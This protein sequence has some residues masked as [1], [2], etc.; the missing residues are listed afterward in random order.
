MR[1]GRRRGDP[2]FLC[3]GKFDQEPVVAS[4][5]DLEFDPC[6]LVKAG[7]DS[8]GRH[9]IHCDG[10]GGVLAFVPF[11]SLPSYVKLSTNRERPTPLWLHSISGTPS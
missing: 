5:R 11:S 1:L 10:E 3:V 6:G 9:V 8:A 4:L 2:A 7:F